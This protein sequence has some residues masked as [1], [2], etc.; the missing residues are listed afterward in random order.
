MT[1]NSLP[2]N[3]PGIPQAATD[4]AGRIESERVEARSKKQ[5]ERAAADALMV[6]LGEAN[7]VQKP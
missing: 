7:I 4:S 2:Q 6:W 3:S 5:A 1:P